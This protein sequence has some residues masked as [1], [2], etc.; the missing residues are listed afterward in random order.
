MNIFIHGLHRIINSPSFKKSRFSRANLT[1]FAIIFATIGGYL[2]YSSFAAT[3]TC[4]GADVTTSTFASRVSGAAAGDVLCLTSGNYGTWA[5]TNKVITITAQAGVTPQMQVNFTTGD[6][7]FTIDGLSGMQGDI[8]GGANNITIKNSAFA[9]SIVI[10]GVSNSNIL[11]D[12]DTFININFPSAGGGQF[13]CA[14]TRAAAVTLPYSQATPSGVTVSN[15]LFQG[16]HKDGVQAG[17]ALNIINNV[18]DNIA[19]HGAVCAPGW[20][21]TS[22]HTDPIQLIYAKGAVVRGNYIHNTSDGIVAYDTIDHAIIENNVLDLVSGRWGIELYSDNGSIVRHNTLVYRTTCEYAPCG[23]I[24]LDHKSTDP[25]GVGT[26]IYDNIAYSIEIQNGS[27][28]TVNNKNMLITGASGTNFSGTPTY[29]GGGGTTLSN[30]DAF[31]LTSTSPGHLAASDGTDAGVYAIG[32]GSGGAPPT[33]TLSA[34]PTTINSGSS[35][36]LTWSSA[37]AT[38]CSA[39]SPSGWTS[40]TATSGTKLVSP[41]STT[42]YTISC[43]GAGGANTANATVTVSLPAG[44]FQSS[45]AWSNHAIT[46]QASSFTFDFDATPQAANINSVVGL[47]NA[48]ATDYTS[49]ATIVR[50]NDTGTIDARNGGAYAAVNNIPYTS[51]TSYHFRLTVNPSIHTYSA[52]VTPSGGAVTTI[53]TNYAFRTEQAGTSTLNNW[54][55]FQDP[56]SVDS[57]TVCNVV[58]NQSTGPKQGDIN[59]DN[60]VNI[61]DLSLLLS[62]Y[63]QNTTQCITNNAYK[64]DLST[65]G[66]GVVNIFDLSILL[67]KYGT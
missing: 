2:I 30:H 37:N 22:P 59:G 5:G 29:V 16:G 32:S 36:T 60:N 48:S 50:F 17:T 61:T 43:A 64:C 15:S 18:F 19:E 47:S 62:S 11:L 65:P 20:W 54:A 41:T 38:S 31:L 24:I 67:S 14:D 57:Q 45:T 49:L 27:T 40:S 21:D 42:T 51:G 55:L 4:T 12:H 7:G 13:T 8:T 34:N 52:T 66:D 23:H 6:S 39:T 1:I 25:A 35:S 46:S 26:Q 3:V 28:A 58:L 33:V 44:C 56:A 10:D 53:A 63:G 9:D